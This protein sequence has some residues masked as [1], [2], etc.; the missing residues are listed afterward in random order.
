MKEKSEEEMNEDK[1]KQ[2]WVNIKEQYYQEVR[3]VLSRHG[4]NMIRFLFEA[5]CGLCNVSIDDMQAHAPTQQA[6][7]A[8]ALFWYVWREATY[9]PYA[10]I[11]MLS[12][13]LGLDF[14]LDSI[15]KSVVTMSDM[16]RTEPIWKRRWIEMKKVTDIIIEKEES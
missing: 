2:D 14:T 8:R 12:K 6:Q 9:E 4:I 1:L 10:K 13:E 11:A 7:Q 3:E 15:R 5:V 16:V